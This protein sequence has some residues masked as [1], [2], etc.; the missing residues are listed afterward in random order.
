[1]MC[2][3]HHRLTAASAGEDLEAELHAETCARCRAELDALTALV[4]LARQLPEPPAL[5]ADRRA[6]IRA[7]AL[8]TAELSARPAAPRRAPPRLR[9]ALGA[10][11]ACAAAAAI[12]IAA[13]HTREAIAPS[14][15][16][17]VPPP[18]AEPSA[19]PAP[20]RAPNAVASAAAPAQTPEQAPA[21]A[22]STP[23]AAA[24]EP[25]RIAAAAPEPAR[26]PP[27]F[28]DTTSTIDARNT[29]PVSLVSGDTT[30]HVADSQVEVT[31]RGGV[32]TAVRVLAGHARIEQR[33]HAQIIATGEIWVRP[34][35][36]PRATPAASLQSFADGWTALRANH[37]ADAIAAF[38]RADDPV[39]VE[40]AAYWA[41]I[42]SARSGD[43][44]GAGRRLRDFLARF[45]TSSRLDA[46]RHALAHLGP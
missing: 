24:S 33:G 15:A 25:P 4:D 8:A 14:A 23:R 10:A 38:D 16:L 37:Y 13:W 9:P 39:I 2:P 30:V 5:P 27:A 41:A 45:P 46:A 20:T 31:S 12:A 44:V 7:A 42:A 18:V 11:A 40:D 43:R 19:A 3:S 34:D 21:P 32:V 26:K 17:T 22:A 1:M 28:H 35:Q 6:A 29:E 36:P